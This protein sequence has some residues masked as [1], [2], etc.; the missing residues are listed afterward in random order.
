MTLKTRQLSDGDGC[1]S[2]RESGAGAPVVLIHGV[3]LQSAAWQPQIT[4]LA[5]NYQ[6]FALD[7]PG[8]GGSDP[9]HSGATLE[10]FV[11]WGERAIRALVSAPVRV[12][13]HSMGALIAG[14]LAVRKP[15]LVERVALLNSVFRRDPQ[16]RLAVEARAAQIGQGVIDVE[17][18]LAR[19][20]SDDAGEQHVRALTAGWLSE[21]TVEGYAT[22][23][24]AFAGGDATFADGLAAVAC[25]LLA[26]TGGDDPNST[27]A[28]AREM[29]AAARNGKAV[30][31]DGQRHMVNLTAPELVNAHLLDWLALPAATEDKP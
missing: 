23:Y 2:Y 1:F 27:P 7:M 13:G 18:P 8:H 16:A 11:V 30:I 19:W 12:A 28:M 20:F 5:Q 21:I 3:G 9:L 22:A 29:A 6:V 17:S 4:A 10:D 14:G 26:L 24:A 25:P 31:I 15:A